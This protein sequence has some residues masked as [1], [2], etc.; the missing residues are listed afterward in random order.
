MDLLSEILQTVK[1]RG[2]VY[3]HARFQSPWGM[4]I[5]S[6]QYA[7]YHIVTDGECWVDTETSQKPIL[8]HKG[9]MVLFPRGDWHSLVDSLQSDVVSAG[10]L[11]DNPHESSSNELILGGDGS[12]SASLICGH[13][14]YD[15][16]LFPHPL[17]ETLPSL[18]YIPAKNRPDSDWF[19]TA[20]EL[21]AQ[22]SKGESLGKEAV[23]NRLAESIFIQALSDYVKSMDDPA[24]FLGAIQDRNIGLALKSIHDDI[25][26]DWNISELANIAAMSKSVFSAKFHQMVGE[27][28]IIYLARWRM[29]KARE[30]LIETTLSISQI[31]EKVGYKSEYSFSRA[32]KKMTL[33]TPGSVRKAALN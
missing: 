16:E 33:Y 11:V 28:P 15:R 3:F 21:A 32:F 19:T 30:M 29:L 20:S 1:L 4:K 10:E 22:I 6:G 18:V 5:P 7:N 26:H 31:S 13:F 27:P 12:Y 25:A 17:F 8:L 23:V 9:D 2:T 24:S 14:E